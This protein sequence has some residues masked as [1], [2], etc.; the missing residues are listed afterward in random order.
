MHP[1]SHHDGLRVLLLYNLNAA[2]PADDLAAAQRDAVSAREALVEAGHVVEEVAIWDDDLA[3]RLRR[4][5]P[6]THVVFNICEE[7]PGIPRSESRVAEV[8]ERL[9]F[10]YTGAPADVLARSWDK[11]GVRWLL[12]RQGLPVP[13]WR[14]FRTARPDGWDCFPAIVKPAYEHC[15]VGLTADAVVFTPAELSRRIAYVLTTFGQPAL[16]EDFID[17]REFHV[18]LWG[19]GVVEML[20]P[21]EMDFT[22]FADPRERLCTY[23]S[24]FCPG[25]PHYERVQVRV[26]AALAPEEAGLLERVSR[27]AYRTLGC[28]DYARLDLRLRDGTFY[29]LDVNP[30][31]DISPETSMVEAARVAGYSYGE[32][33]SHVVLLAAQRH[34]FFGRHRH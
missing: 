12:G 22:A 16:V 14:V 18:G 13:R 15:S 33:L 11:V 6:T 25:T 2:W 30:N 8:L 34:S 17:G 23:E 3:G 26:P 31:P 5:S 1:N 27:A 9:G 4:Y 28:R 32:L 20:P 19:N 10:T 24:K 21:A 7:L 29:V